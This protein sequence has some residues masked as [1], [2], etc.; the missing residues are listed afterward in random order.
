MLASESK[1]KSGIVLRAISL[2][3]LEILRQLAN[4]LS[5]AEADLSAVDTR[6]PVEF[7][8]MRGIYRLTGGS[9]VS[10]TAE[11]SMAY[12]VL[13]GRKHP[14]LLLEGRTGERCAHEAPRRGTRKSVQEA[15]E[16]ATAYDANNLNQYTSIQTGEEAAFVPTFDADGNQTKV[17]TSTGIWN[18]V[19]NAENRPVTFTSEDG[20]TVVECTYDYMGRRHTRKI[21][22]NG[23]VT[24]Y[25]RYIYRGYLQIAAIN[26]VSGVFQWFILW[27]PT[28]SVATRPLGIR[29]DGTWYTYGWDLT[30][31]ICE[32]FGSD[33]YIK[34]AY[35]Y[36]PYGS[37]TANGNVTQ[38]IQWSSE[39]ND[40]ELGLVYYNYRHYNPADGR[41]I[42]E[43]LLE[44]SNSYAYLANN[45]SLNDYLGLRTDYKPALSPGTG[46]HPSA[47]KPLR[48]S[49]PRT[50]ELRTSEPRTP[51]P[52]QKECSGHE[53]FRKTQ[54][55]CCEYRTTEQ[56]RDYTPS[57][58]G[59][60]SDGDIS[61]DIVPNTYFEEAC[62]RHDVCYGTCGQDREKC[63]LKFKDDMYAICERIMNEKRGRN[64][65]DFIGDLV[66]GWGLA[67]CKALAY[68]YYQ[69]V[70]WWGASAY[71]AAQD[72][73]CEWRSCTEH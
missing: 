13:M 5:T 36:T 34:T 22:V 70:V 41:W 16:E 44:Q 43:D 14:F 45:I 60:G 72:E 39:Y 18:V 29:K 31:N 46:L 23:S 48:T 56:K 7:L 8:H 17:Q 27:D 32:V 69:P 12:R 64:P 47:Y 6:V 61:G 21:T 63:D 20:A 49:E 58:N 51:E 62:N 50:S 73:A 40:S 4:P 19:Y 42:N 15:A 2:G 68:A 53:R 10:Y 30:K 3:P 57:F 54:L 26:A 24:N 59:C 65:Y 25:L 71:E 11:S 1:T 66:Y 67:S 38:P 28:Q 37:V 9:A 35:T 33:G 55:G 52:C